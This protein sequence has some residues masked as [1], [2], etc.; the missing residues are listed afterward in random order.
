MCPRLLLCMATSTLL[1]RELDLRKQAD[2]AVANV[3]IRR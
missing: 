2:A 3:G 1:G